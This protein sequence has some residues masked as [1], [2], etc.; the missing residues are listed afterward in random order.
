MKLLLL[1]LALTLTGCGQYGEPIWLAQMYDS[2]DPCQSRNW[3][4]N[5]GHMDLTNVPRGKQSGYPDF[6]GAG[7]GARRTTI[8]TMDNRP[9]GYT[10]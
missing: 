7:G 1:A 4:E 5:G 10:R 6:C 2:R 9:I 3:R 8:Y